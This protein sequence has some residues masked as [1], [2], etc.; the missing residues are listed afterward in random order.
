M[1][2]LIT[3]IFPR[4]GLGRPRIEAEESS[5]TLWNNPG[6]KVESIG[7]ADGFYVGMRAREEPRITPKLLVLASGKMEVPATM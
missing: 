2:V 4:I 1:N 6:E 5:R 7:F 3:Y